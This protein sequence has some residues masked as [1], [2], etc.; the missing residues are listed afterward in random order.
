MSTRPVYVP[1]L[2]ARSLGIPGAVTQESPAVMHCAGSSSLGSF[3][4]DFNHR[5]ITRRQDAGGQRY[6][7][8]ELASKQRF[9]G[10]SPPQKTSSGDLSRLRMRGTW[11]TQVPDARG[12]RSGPRPFDEGV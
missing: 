12:C 2:T 7:A 10:A 6:A 4:R 8:S 3:R 11:S 9:W 5:R 1:A